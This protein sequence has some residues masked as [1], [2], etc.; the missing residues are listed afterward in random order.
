MRVSILCPGPV[1]TNPDGL[2]RIESQGGKGKVL[3][4]LP[5]KVARIAIKQMLRNK[6]I[7]IP[8]A[9]PIAIVR[10]LNLLP[11]LWRM[12]VLERVFRTYRDM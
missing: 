7:I 2:K 3:M 6:A 8:G 10:V 4:T 9:L 5:D 11:I 1:L 12:R